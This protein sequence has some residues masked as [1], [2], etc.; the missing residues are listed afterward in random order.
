MLSLII[1][2]VVTGAVGFLII[3]KNKPQT[4]L[5]AGGIILLGITVLMGYPILEAKKSTGLY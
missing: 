4:V 1:A 5:L 3:R 2:L